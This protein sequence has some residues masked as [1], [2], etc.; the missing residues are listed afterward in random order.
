VQAC[1][2]PSAG[3]SAQSGWC[4][5]ARSWDGAGLGYGPGACHAQRR[6]QRAALVHHVL[7][8]VVQVRHAEQQRRGQHRRR[9]AAPLRQVRHLRARRQRRPGDTEARACA[10]AGAR[11]CVCVNHM[12]KQRLV[13]TVSAGQLPGLSAGPG[14]SVANN[15]HMADATTPAPTGRAPAPGA[16]A[17]CTPGTQTPPSAAPPPRCAGPAAAGALAERARLLGRRMQHVTAQQQLSQLRVQHVAPVRKHLGLLLSPHPR[18]VG[19]GQHLRSLR[20]CARAGGMCRA[21]LQ[22]RQAQQGEPWGARARRPRE[23]QQRAGEQGGRQRQGRRE[24]GGQA[25]RTQAQQLQRRRARAR[26]LRGRVQRS[27]QGQSARSLAGAGP[28]AAPDERPPAPFKWHNLVEI[29]RPQQAGRN[30][31]AA[32]LAAIG[33]ACTGQAA[34]CLWSQTADDGG[35]LP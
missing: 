27:R 33:R 25:A 6:P 34:R 4:R 22:A 19:A 1:A 9:D 16:A 5:C 7:A 14:E 3:R 11:S 30:I 23:Q 31:P 13:C 24:R 8:Q 21:R 10:W 32:H 15:Q 17:P 20:V 26:A 2:T 18:A 29:A 12:R 35:R 28:A